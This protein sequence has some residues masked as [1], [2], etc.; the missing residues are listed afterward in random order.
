MP[1]LR[2]RY[3]LNALIRKLK[4]SRVVSIQ[5]ARQTGK[6]VL[7]R[8]IFDQGYYVTLDKSSVRIEAKERTGVF[9]ETI[10]QS[11]DQRSVVIDEA[12]KVPELFDEIKSFVDLDQRPGQFLLLGSTEFS[13]ETKIMESLT[14]RLSR[15]KLYPLTFS[16][17]LE[18]EQGGLDFENRKSL[19]KFK[20]SELIKFLNRGG[21]P[22]SF[23]IRDQEE[24]RSKLEEWVKLTCER[25]ALQIATIKTD[26]NLC[27]RILETL[28]LLEEPN[29]ASLASKFKISGKKIQSQLKALTLIFAVHEVRPHAMGSGKP[30]Y[31]L[32]DSGLVELFGGSFERKLETAILTELLAKASYQN[33]TR[34]HLYFYRSRIGSRVNFLLELSPTETLAI[35]IVGSESLDSRELLILDSLKTKLTKDKIN[36]KCFLLCGIEQGY[37]LKSKEHTHWVLPWESVF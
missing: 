31:F 12:Q 6:S 36:S 9:L 2:Q 7:A 29:V 25:D 34:F 26:P 21:F 16:E 13:R 1:H 27:V 22:S 28:P 30:L 35:K 11:A 20:R 8:D 32:I 24:R 37:R 5:G 3:A 33:K 4:F 17:T 10:K 15:M 23:S 14:G 19:K 18:N